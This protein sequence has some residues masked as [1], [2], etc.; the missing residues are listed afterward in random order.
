MQKT[1]VTISGLPGSGKSSTADLVAKNLNF[2]RFSSGDL[3]REVGMRRGLSIEETSRA[4]MSDPAFDKEVDGALQNL[5]KEK[6]IVIDSRLAFHW[7]RQSFK[8]FLKIDP[9]TA[10]RRIFSQ[11]H[12]EG[13]LAQYASSLEDVHKKLLARIET[14]K[15]RYKDKYGVDY[16]DESHY[17]LVIDTAKFPLEEVAAQIVAAY[18]SQKS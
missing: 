12:K 9:E 2:K 1:I 3:M 13:R 17:D 14:E 4:A 5:A 16:T 8:V 15:T 11:L 7:I 10:A 6:D 18:A